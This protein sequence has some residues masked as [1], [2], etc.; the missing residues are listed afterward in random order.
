MKKKTNDIK[1][2]N[3]LTWFLF[4]WGQYCLDFI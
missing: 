4:Q 3:Q 1:K 2:D